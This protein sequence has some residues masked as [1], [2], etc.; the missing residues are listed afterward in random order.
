MKIKKSITDRINEINQLL[1]TVDDLLSYPITYLDGTFPSYVIVT[2]PIEIK[3]QFVYIHYDKSFD[4]YDQGKIRF[5][6]N[7]KGKFD[8]YGED[9]L[10]T[11]LKV[12]LKAFKKAI[13]ED[14]KYEI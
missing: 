7:K 4:N 9:Y 5:N 10:I 2:Q 6:V 11:D 12:I 13:K 8:E 1:P 3:N 14:N